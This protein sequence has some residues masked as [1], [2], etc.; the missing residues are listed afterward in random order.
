MQDTKFTV[1]IKNNIKYIIG[2]ELGVF[3]GYKEPR[4]AVKRFCKNIEKEL[5]QTKGGPQKVNIIKEE[6]VVIMI[7]N[8]NL[9]SKTFKKELITHLKGL[10]IIKNSENFIFT[11]RKEIVFVDKL[12]DAL[13]P[14]DLTIETQRQCG[15]FR[16]DVYIPKLNIAIEYDENDHKGYSYD[17]QEG[18]QAIIEKELGCRFI[19]VSDKNTD[20]YNI[21]YIIKNIFNI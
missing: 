8:C 21:G 15:K 20:S 16:I 5:I 4:K 18:R 12:K 13:K 6:D 17:E 11:E 14:F 1:I 19:R 7:E 9:K 3:L 2:K 10:D